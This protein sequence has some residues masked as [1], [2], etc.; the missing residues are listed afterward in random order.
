MISLTNLRSLH[1]ASAY[2][3]E[4]D[5]LHGI[6]LD[7]LQDFSEAAFIH[8]LS[9][10]DDEF[11]MEGAGAEVW[12]RI[13]KA[14]QAIV[15]FFKTLGTKIKSFVAGFFKKAEEAVDKAEKGGEKSE[16]SS[17]DIPEEQK[18]EIKLLEE[19]IKDKE[20]EIKETP[21]NDAEKVEEL[22]E[23]IAEAKEKVEEIKR[24]YTRSTRSYKDGEKIKIRLL[25]IHPW[26]TS[27]SIRFCA[28]KAILQ[29]A[30]RN[31]NIDKIYN[32]LLTDKFAADVVGKTLSGRIR[33]NGPDPETK[34]L[35]EEDGKAFLSVTVDYDD[36]AVLKA[37][38]LEKTGD[39]I[40]SKSIEAI[41]KIYQRSDAI[42][43]IQKTI[44]QAKKNLAHMQDDFAAA[45]KVFTSTVSNLN[46]YKKDPAAADYAQVL[47]LQVQCCNKVIGVVN[48]MSSYHI[49]SIKSAIQY[50]IQQ[51]HQYQ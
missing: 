3:M 5:Y 46:T 20:Q 48:K 36:P 10:M 6:E 12:S 14:F 25:T 11:L 18:K 47:K 37:L 32:N 23:D 43:E 34:K 2:D 44:N 29:T 26:F 40:K 28:T 39:N 8:D 22:K 15:N 49:K 51:L 33:D 35:I 50:D 42:S 7:D 41:E 24:R 16:S 21:T 13:K 30:N 38:E 31:A 19:K 17:E 1:E 45:E 27:L 9:D 4:D